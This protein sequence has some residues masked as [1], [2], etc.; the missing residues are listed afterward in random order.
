MPRIN[1]LPWRDEQRKE[2]KLKFMVA[3]GVT[4]AINMAIFERLAEFG[5]MRALGDR[6]GNVF[7]LVMIECALL[8]AVGAGAGVLAGVAIAAIVSATGIPMPPPPNS[9]IGFTARMS[10]SLSACA[11]AFA[12]GA[13]A[14]LLAGV[15]PALRAR[16]EPIVD[17]LR[18]A[19]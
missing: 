11:A 5:T 2:R 1:L 13:G 12:I 16:G 7:R 9:N 15:I 18:R 19:I 14:T 10:L 8:G 17:A 4:N 3:L 6:S